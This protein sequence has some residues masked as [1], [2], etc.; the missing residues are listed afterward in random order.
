MR[1]A[2]DWTAAAL[3]A[4]LAAP[5]MVVAQPQAGE[6]AIAQNAVAQCQGKP[7]LTAPVTTLDRV[8][9]LAGFDPEIVSDD[10]LM[11]D[12]DVAVEN[13]G[14]ADAPH[15][16]L[17]YEAEV[18]TTAGKLVEKTSNV[19]NIFGVPAGGVEHALISIMVSELAVCLQPTGEIAATIVIRVKVDVDDEVEECDETD[20]AAEATFEIATEKVVS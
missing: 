11:V 20:N 15:S 4:L 1:R 10:V 12:F 3:C 9:Y 7:N 19:A 5:V 14:A 13:V 2:I 16:R 6:D 8:D 18:Y 17:R